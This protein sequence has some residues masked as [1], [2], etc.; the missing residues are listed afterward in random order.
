MTINFFLVLYIIIMINNKI[1]LDANITTNSLLS[2]TFVSHPAFKQDMPNDSYEASLNKKDKEN[3]NL[4]AAIG[5]I[6]ALA[7]TA[8]GVARHKTGKIL[9][10]VGAEV[11]ASLIKRFQKIAYVTSKDGMTGL[12]NKSSLLVSL[13]DDF[14]DVVQRKGKLSVA[15][16]D[17]D[18]FKGINEVFNHDKGDFVL[19]RIA[20]NIQEVAQ[21]YNLKGFRYGGEEFVVLMKDMKPEDSEK[22][23][24][25]ISDAIMND[26]QIQDLLPEFLSSASKETVHLDNITGKIDFFFDQVRSLDKSKLADPKNIEERRMLA[27]NISSFISNYIG[28]SEASDKKGLKNLIELLKN[29]TDAELNDILDLNNFKL[30]KELNIIYNNSVNKRN[31]LFKWTNHL[32]NHKKFTVSGGL[33]DFDP[34]FAIDE[35]NVLLQTADAALKMAKNDGKNKIVIAS[36]D[37]LK[38]VMASSKKS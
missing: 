22:V 4:K 29:S 25:E 31:E 23:V 10:T 30:T 9:K 26:K 32:F 38:E 34:N 15:M 18:N 28:D 36:P 13:A 20:A 33:I 11:P 5:T 19:K 12:F 2:Q 6:V 3:R 35:S 16:L 14:K 27:D 17:M 37:L 21:K 7:G 1:N 8:Y 24:R